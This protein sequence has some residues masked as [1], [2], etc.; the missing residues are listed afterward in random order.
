[1]LRFKLCCELLSCVYM[2]SFVF[3]VGVFNAMHILNISL[4]Q[5]VTSGCVRLAYVF[6]K[7]RLGYKRRRWLVWYCMQFPGVGNVTQ[8]LYWLYQSQCEY[9]WFSVVFSW[10]R[11]AVDG[12]WTHNVDV[13]NVLPQC[14]ITYFQVDSVQQ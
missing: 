13:K 12:I 9:M 8:T 4:L 14:I 6:K 10:Q 1:M 7:F 3:F 11:N 2:Y 5:D